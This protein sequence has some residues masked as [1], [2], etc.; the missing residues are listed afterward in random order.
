MFSFLARGLA[1]LSLALKQPLP[2]FCEIETAYG[3]ALITK[4]GHYLS[5]IRVDGI[6]RMAERKDFARITEAMRMD[7]SGA[8]ETRGH[9]IVGWYISDPD[10]ALV[11]IAH[12]NLNACRAVA[13]EAG[14]NLD[15]I[16]AERAR[17]WPTLMRWE[18][19]YFIVWTRP[20]ALTKE[21]R[22]QLK[23]EYAANAAAAGAIGDT[24]RFT[25]HSEIMATR[26]AAFTSRVLSALRAHD[27]AASVLEPHEALQV[28]RAAMY[29]EMAA[30]EWRPALPGDRVMVRCPEDDVKQPKVD[31]LLWPPIREQIFYT[32][33]VTQG[34]QRVEFGDNAY[35][36]VDMYLGP[37][38][39]RPFVELAS[40][41]GQDRIPWR[42]SI[43]LEGGGK[44]S[45]QLKDIGAS[46]LAMFP[47]NADLRR[48]FAFLKETREKENHISVK[49][50]AS[51]A[52][53]APVE[54]PAKLR[55]R[56]STLSQRIEGW[57]N[58]K[59]TTVV[60][61][62]LEGVMS[63]APGLAFAS[64]ANPSLALLG[65]ALTMLPWNR[66]ASPWESGSVL[67]RRP[68]GGIWPYDPAGGRQRPLVCDIF[69]APP[70]SGKSVLAN[71]INMASASARR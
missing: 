55:R 12:L 68:D 26:H 66:T 15:D 19:S 30:S 61:D 34:G 2:A 5:W 48:G 53:W 44:A 3:D 41:L 27:V 63:S 32:D 51:F 58:A 31:C 29:R 39:P 33:A 59:A 1:S 18:A 43:F 7:L 25:L 14:L 56:I 71:T 60:G 6:Q 67:F 42:A 37:E 54:Q 46:F 24:Q 57:G 36:C 49:L 64:T 70:G 45:M 23:A 20:N 52:T 17:L 11:E 28:A 69:V 38:D 10:A 21:E 35:G 65:D 13:R 62:P 16:L 22:K 40:T 4:A 8:L 9:A 47:G 50:R